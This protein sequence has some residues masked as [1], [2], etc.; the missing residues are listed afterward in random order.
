MSITFL[1]NSSLGRKNPTAGAKVL[2]LMRVLGSVGYVVWCGIGWYVVVLSSDDT[3]TWPADLTA[4]HARPN[5]FPARIP[6]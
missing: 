6:S 5:D 3:L 1:T 2:I 4:S